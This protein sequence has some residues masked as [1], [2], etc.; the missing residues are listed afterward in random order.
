MQLFEAFQPQKGEI[1]VI[2]GG[3][4]KTSLMYALGR[5]AFR[6][7]LR[8]VFTTT[9]KLL[10]P[11]TCDLEVI[12][13]D[14]PSQLGEQLKEQ[15]T[16]GRLQVVCSGISPEGKL[17]GLQPRDIPRLLEGEADL[18]LV[19]GDGSA[20]RPFKAPGLNEPVIPAVA[21]LVVPVV[22]IDCL[23][24]P[25][26]AEFVHRPEKVEQLTGLQQGQPV[27]PQVVA[28]VLTHPLGYGGNLPKDCRWLPFINKV[29]NPDQLMQAR[30]IV[31]RMAIEKTFPARSFRVVLGA[32]QNPDPVLEIWDYT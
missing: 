26:T 16:K 2:T 14:Q 10:P 7:G 11:K 6:H 4:G 19:E 9:T 30:E 32:I 5:E 28:Q 31:E 3:G 8:P 15:S 24:R 27:T 13:V 23:G 12:I 21:T 1:I 17:L 22:G 20:G 29:E 25:L 18:V